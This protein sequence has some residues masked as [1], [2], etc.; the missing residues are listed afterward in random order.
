MFCGSHEWLRVCLSWSTNGDILIRLSA[1]ELPHTCLFAR[2]TSSP[3]LRF[4]PTSDSLMI[5]HAANYRAYICGILCAPSARTS[6]NTREHV[7]YYSRTP[8]L[9]PPSKSDWSGRKRGVVAHEGLDYFITRAH[10]YLILY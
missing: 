4:R 1:K 2:K 3:Q 9:R 10:W 6:L 8:L 5:I 7:G